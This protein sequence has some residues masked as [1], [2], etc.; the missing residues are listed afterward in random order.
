[1]DSFW[2]CTYKAAEQYALTAAQIPKDQQAKHKGRGQPPAMV[3]KP[4]LNARP[5]EAC[6]ADP[7]CSFWGKVCQAVGQALWWPKHHKPVPVHL[8]KIAS[9]LS[10]QVMEF[11]SEIDEAP[12]PIS[13][14]ATTLSN[15]AAF[16]QDTLEG[17][18]AYAR[19]LRDHLGAKA[20]AQAKEYFRKRFLKTWLSM[21]R[22][23]TSCANLRGRCR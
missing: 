3:Y 22:S 20:A 9:R 14:V 2:S 19:C 17:T 5:P 7:A 6:S 13:E 12:V 4:L 23:R 10:E 11:E 21:H 1:M 16:T 15:L 18:Y 8:V